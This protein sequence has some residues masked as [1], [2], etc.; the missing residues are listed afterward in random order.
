MT[1]IYYSILFYKYL[2]KGNKKFSHN[3]STGF[4]SD[5]N[6]YT[7]ISTISE[8]DV[9]EI[10]YP[11]P[12]S[13]WANSIGHDG[14]REAAD[15]HEVKNMCGGDLAEETSPGCWSTPGCELDGDA[16]VGYWLI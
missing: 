2:G 15:F 9:N 16:K 11:Q 4:T 14:K 12:R 8:A 1:V 13:S 10:L 3:G 6:L 7:R 5:E